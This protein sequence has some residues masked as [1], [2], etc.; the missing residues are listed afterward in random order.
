MGGHLRKK[1]GRAVE[2]R[3]DTILIVEDSKS[4]HMALKPMLER[5][6]TVHV[7]VAET[8][9]EAVKI[10]D[11]QGPSL[12]LAILDLALPD[13]MN[14]EIADYAVAHNVPSLVFTSTFDARV[15]DQIL[16]RGII[17]YVIKSSRSV[18]EIVRT[19]LRLQ[20]NRKIRVLVVD[21]SA[22]A[23]NSIR[24]SLELY[25]FQVATAAS[26]QE[27]LDWLDR[28]QGVDLVL[29]DFEMAGMDGV[30]LTG[31]IRRTFSKEEVVIV[32]VSAATDES[33]APRFLKNGAN[34][35]MRKPLAREEFYCRVL[36]NIETLEHIRRAETWNLKLKESEERY[37]DLVEYAPIGIFQSTPEGRYLSANTRLIEMYGY[38]SEQDLLMNVH[39][40][41]EQ[42]YV[43][44]SEREKIKRA[45]SLGIIDR[46]EVQRRRKDGSVI[47]VSLSERVV[48]D[49][50]GAIL[51]YEGF[52]R[53]I[54]ARKLDAELRRH[55]ERIIQHDL[56][57]PACNVIGVAKMLGDEAGISREQRD[58]YTILEQTGQNML[59]TLNSSLS[60]Y[61]IETGQF[62]L[63]A[64]VFNCVDV[65]RRLLGTLSKNS[66]FSANTLVAMFDGKPLATEDG[67]L[68]LGDPHLFHAAL[69]NL[70]TN[71]LE[72]SP[73][74]A[75]VV[76]QFF[77]GKD[78]RIE[79]WNKGT[80]P[81]AIRDRF[82]EKNVTMGKAQGTGLGTYAALMMIQAQRGRVTMRTFD[83][84]NETVL[85]V[86]LPMPL[87]QQTLPSC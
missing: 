48:R 14:G 61:K 23:R 16:T 82:F 59:D 10:I 73:H 45:L 34:D 30:E 29:T 22:S 50:N 35:F 74:G 53:D 85:T 36:N 81:L 12:F 52:S 17:D 32:G 40:I 11:L 5:V 33:L 6:C 25:M 27:A 55:I 75:E 51:H 69:Q 3:N 86:W 67:C 15:R 42:V 43:D 24:A 54:T 66:V 80:V 8:Y 62:Q 57:T 72:A 65:L 9:A 87:S 77:T 41:G 58:L 49:R 71:A 83:R 79:V 4:I 46:M 26:G 20:L 70:V 13:A 37:R 56:R 63:K 64:E 78:C 21:D 68:C 84:E 18:E 31:R 47:W 39:D 19:V 60:L 28:G 7:L 1:E 44:A 2:Q 76:L 38:D